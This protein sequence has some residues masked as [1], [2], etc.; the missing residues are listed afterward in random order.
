MLPVFLDIRG[1]IY[2]NR[3][4]ESQTVNQDYY[5]KNFENSVKE[6]KR[7][8]PIC[9]K[10]KHHHKKLKTFWQNTLPFQ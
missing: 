2:I 4:P 8:A 5:F 1:A 10:E 7:K 6:F 9:G 3:I